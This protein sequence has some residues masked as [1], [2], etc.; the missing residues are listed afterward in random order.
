MGKRVCVLED[1]QGIREIIE[2]LLS[3]ENYEVAGFSNIA[4]FMV[5]ARNVIPDLFLLDVMLPDGSGMDVCD[6]LK[7]SARTE[8]VPVL[9]M[10]AHAALSD[11]KNGCKAQDFISKPFDIY[12]LLKRVDRQLKD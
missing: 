7:S 10:S 8:N 5:N 1:D 2:F 6:L 12:D 11:V 3:E 4:D 9:M